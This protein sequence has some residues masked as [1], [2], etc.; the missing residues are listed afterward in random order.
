MAFTPEQDAY[1]AAHRYAEVVAATDLF[2]E[3][4]SYLDY[5]RRRRELR[6]AGYEVR[7]LR[8]RPPSQPAIHLSS[9]PAIPA[10]LETD[11]LWEAIIALQ[12]QERRIFPS[13]I[14]VAIETDRPIGVVFTSD[15]HIG[16]SGTDHERLLAD[17]ETIATFPGLFAYVGGDPTDNMVTAKLSHV[18]RDEQLVPPRDQWRLYRSLIEK[19]RPS[20]IAI[21]RGNH[22]AWTQR[23]AGIDGIE[24]ALEGIPVIQTGEDTYIE[25]VVGEQEYVIY[26]KHRPIASSRTHRASGAKR[27]YDWGERT[28][29]VGVTEHHHEASLTCEMRHGRYRWFITTGS[30]KVRDA[31]A[32]EG[33]FVHGG[34]RMPVVIFWPDRHKIIAELGID[35][36]IERL[37]RWYDS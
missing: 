25:L 18:A 19:L 30:Y 16:S 31:Y 17:V 28:F 3:P 26:R 20:L 7:D 24:A 21:G 13:S 33:G 8:G 2:P 14:R 29:D 15:W 22:D 35:D 37:G 32:R 12:R 34:P 11:Q 10:S 27:A 9:R 23:V 36:A 6:E 4:P 5:L 1:L